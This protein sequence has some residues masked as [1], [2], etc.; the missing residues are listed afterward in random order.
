MTSNQVVATM[1][2]PRGK[3]E[4]SRA[5]ALGMLVRKLRRERGLTLDHLA[6]RVP[7]SPSNL[8]R[9]ELGSQGPPTE[10]VIERL[11]H[12]LDVPSNELRSAAGLRAEGDGFEDAVLRRLDELRNEVREVR[13][14]VAAAAGK[15]VP[16]ERRPRD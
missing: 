13:D 8:S 2:S 16:H 14:A 3:K 7:M 9:I 10:E 1:A 12:A 5:E 15:A 4:T 11:A 6:G